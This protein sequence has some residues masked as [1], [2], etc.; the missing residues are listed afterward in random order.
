MRRSSQNLM[1]NGMRLH[2]VLLLVAP[3]AAQNATFE[4]H[5]ALTLANDKI[6]LLVLKQGAS[7]ASVVLRDDAAKLNPL[8]DP[9][10]MARESGARGGFNS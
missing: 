4:D 7:V 8:W 1:I 3:L 9:A 10:R 2:L 5:P 6:E